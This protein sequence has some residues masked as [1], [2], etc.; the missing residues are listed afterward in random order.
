MKS[1]HTSKT[2][3]HEDQDHDKSIDE[4]QELKYNI[5]FVI[6][7]M[8]DAAEQQIEKLKEY[9]DY[10]GISLEDILFDLKRTIF[11]N[12]PD[13]QYESQEELANQDNEEWNC[14]SAELI[15]N[16]EQI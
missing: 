14:S 2:V 15:E 6:Q 16:I 12:Q 13:Q 3:T 10:L 4:L 11:L 8:V 7:E 5:E 1:Y 9:N